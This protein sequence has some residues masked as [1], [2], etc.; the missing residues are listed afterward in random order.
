MEDRCVSCGE[1]IP[2]GRQVCTSCLPPDKV[3][4][5]LECCAKDMC[6]ECPYAG[7]TLKRY[8][9]NQL[10]IDANNLVNGGEL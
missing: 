9:V 2:E 8:C 7:A 10:I 1:I 6:D 5:A 4:R 3:K